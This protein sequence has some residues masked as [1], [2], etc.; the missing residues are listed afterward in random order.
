[1]HVFKSFWK[2]KVAWALGKYIHVDKS[3]HKS[4]WEIRLQNEMN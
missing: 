2:Y 3:N 4:L 1:M